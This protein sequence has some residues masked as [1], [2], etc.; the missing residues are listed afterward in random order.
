LPSADNPAALFVRA[1]FVGSVALTQ[2]SQ[3]WGGQ[4][5]ISAACDVGCKKASPW[6]E[7]GGEEREGRETQ[8]KL[9]KEKRSTDTSVLV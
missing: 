2:S 1:V 4:I 9:I 5:C 6:G 7:I 8:E 3:Y